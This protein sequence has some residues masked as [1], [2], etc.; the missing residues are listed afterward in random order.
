MLLLYVIIKRKSI[1]DL[2][3]KENFLKKYA[4]FFDEFKDDGISS[5]MF[6]LIFVIRRLSLVMIILFVSNPV[7][8]LALSV[9]FTLIVRFMQ[10]PFYLF[11]TGAYKETISGVYIALNEVLTCIYYIVI[12]LPFVASVN[13]SKQRLATYCI[14]IILAALILNILSSVLITIKNIRNWLR[15]RRENKK[16][17]VLPIH[18]KEDAVITSINYLSS[19]TKRVFETQA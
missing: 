9:S 15:K 18:I 2:D 6:Y 11:Q 13:F 1:I 14:E 17:K 19:T 12:S 10:I 8:Q 5:W 16:N 7:L 4:T 3:E